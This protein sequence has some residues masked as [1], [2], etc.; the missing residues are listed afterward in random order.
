MTLWRY[1]AVP[2]H[3]R[4]AR[5]DAQTQRSGVRRGELAGESAM[6][7]RS[8]LRRI[9]LQAIDVKPLRSARIKSFSLSEIPAIAR[10]VRARRKFL[11]AEL[12]DSLATMLNAGL[13]LLEAVE[14]VMHARSADSDDGTDGSR[15]QSFIDRAGLGKLTRLF[16]GSNFR[17]FPGGEM[18]EALRSGH[19]LAEAMADQP[20]WFDQS[21]IAMVRAGQHGGTL[22]RVLRVLADRQQ[23]SNQLSSKLAGA[24]AYPTAVA[25]IGI[26][27]VVFLSS[28]T[29]PE[30]VT[31]LT[32]AGIDPPRLTAA[33]MATGQAIASWWHLILL[34]LMIVIG[35]ALVGSELLRRRQGDD[36]RTLGDKPSSAS[37]FRGRGPRGRG[38][39]V[40]RR[41]AVGR[42][43]MELS[44]LLRTGVPVIDS[45]RVLAPTMTSRRLRTLIITAAD[46]VEQ[47]DDL[48]ISLHDRHWFDAEFTR[49]VEVGQT[50]GEL[51][52]LLERLG[53][54]Y[55]REAE[56]LIDRLTTLLEP[57]VILA[58]AALVGM[59]VMAAVLPLL[60]IQEIL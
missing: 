35:G 39:K 59:V 58:L 20:L 23:R 47:G 13:P 43:A 50:A 60:R 9:G 25:V 46:Q 44:E 15:K 12:Y 7:V 45:L 11:R 31:I 55:L 56:R 14:T 36:Q 18:R 5:P 1:V 21:E 53:E 6:E 22:A 16:S 30:L 24:L 42:F 4:S 54:R 29:L 52:D 28:K 27:V 37:R 3:P 8:S 41:L 57:C 2:S 34:G 48:A 38:I 32:D 17:G 19:S 33:V 10:H 51:D 40:M 49:L 26:G